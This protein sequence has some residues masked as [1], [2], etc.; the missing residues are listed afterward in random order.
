MVDE[1]IVAILLGAM[2]NGDTCN[3]EKGGCGKGPATLPKKTSF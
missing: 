2:P 1:T 3:V